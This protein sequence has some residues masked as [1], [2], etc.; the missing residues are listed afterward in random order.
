MYPRLEN[1]I[2]LWLNHRLNFVT[3]AEVVTSFM[4]LIH[5]KDSEVVAND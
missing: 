4:Q 3:P 1:N 2:L 5:F